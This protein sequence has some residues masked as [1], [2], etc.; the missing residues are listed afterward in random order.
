MM[1]PPSLRKPGGLSMAAS[2]SRGGVS[3]DSPL[4]VAQRESTM[5]LPS[6][7]PSLSAV[8]M[9]DS[10]AGFVLSGEWD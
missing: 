6:P 2:C 5:A 4:L 1:L 9:T 3:M 8:G 7:V 10:P